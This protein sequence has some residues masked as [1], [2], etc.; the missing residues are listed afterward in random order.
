MFTVQSG[1]KY[2][3]HFTLYNCKTDWWEL[4]KKNYCRMGKVAVITGASSG[5]GGT[6]KLLASQYIVIG[7][8]FCVVLTLFYP[9]CGP[10][11]IKFSNVTKL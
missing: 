8:G 1:T 4:V 2:S 6:A 10:K 11:V 7:L 3:V 5:G 9:L